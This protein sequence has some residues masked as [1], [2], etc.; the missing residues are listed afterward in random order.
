[1]TGREAL[2]ARRKQLVDRAEHERA[3]LARQLGQWQRPLLVIDRSVSLLRRLWESP[4]LRTVVCAGIAV[5]AI[6]RPR[7]VMG[8]VGGGRAVWRLV[9]TVLRG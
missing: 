4:L 5:L 7:K 8:W 2:L 1:M 6:S 9:N 3:D